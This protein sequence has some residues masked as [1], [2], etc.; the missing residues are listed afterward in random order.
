MADNLEPDE[1][2]VLNAYRDLKKKGHGDLNMEVGEKRAEVS[3]KRGSL[4][5]VWKTEKL[6]LDKSKLKE[7]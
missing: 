5:K 3:V 6:E 1:E 2:I 7:V 4:V